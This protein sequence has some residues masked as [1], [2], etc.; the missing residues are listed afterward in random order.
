MPGGDDAEAQEAFEY[1]VFLSFASADHEAAEAIYRTLA[2]G[3]LKVFWAPETLR[4]VLGQSFF[5]AIQE[6]L[7]KSRHFVLHWTAQAKSSGWVAAEYEVFFGQCYVSSHG[8]R[9]LIILPDDR[10]PISSLPSLLQSLQ[11]ARSSEEVLD[12]L[13]G[14]LDPAVIEPIDPTAGTAMEGPLGMR[15]RFV[16]SGIYKIGSPKSEPGRF[17]NETHHEVQLTR[18]LWLAET[19]MTQWQW[20]Q[21]V[22]GPQQP[23]RFNAGSGDLPV[24][25]VNWFEA[26]E[27]A[28][29]LSDQEGRPRCY[30]MVNPRGTLETGD[31]ACDDAVFAGLD[32]PGYR[33]PT[34]AEWEIAARAGT[35][36]AIY[37]GAL[38][39]A[40]ERNGPEL[41]PIAWYGGNSGVSYEPAV[42]SS[43]RIEMQFEAARSGPHPVGRKIP[44]PWGFFDLLGNV[45]EWTGDWF[46]AYPEGRVVD[47]VGPSNG[48]FR[49]L[50]G[51]SW[52]SHAR[53]VR[54][55]YR[56]R[57]GPSHPRYVRPKFRGESWY[58]P[59][60]VRNDNLGF[61][62]ARGQ[63]LR[64]SSG[65]RIT[66]G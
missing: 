19:P 64:L 65:G 54:A 29:R 50:R 36:T 52:D 45:Y 12:R 3:G 16:P 14:R 37:T 48:M 1:D 35:P 40:G 28:N 41:D 43:K 47:P 17:E 2:Q 32:C 60:L 55:A 46:G 38:M 15:M 30:E 53:I 5:A 21:L 9:R 66:G 7:V 61:R 44:N 27:F 10:E 51:G 34:E 62:L 11:F 13:G 4:G 24:E 25:G 33:L 57:Y 63:S 6:S 18:G 59:P 23:S 22:P 58:D 26:V 8:A 20:R 39:L 56:G 49:V 31:Y 42:D